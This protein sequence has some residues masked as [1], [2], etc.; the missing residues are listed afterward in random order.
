MLERLPSDVGGMVYDELSLLELAALAD[1]QPTQ[2]AKIEA[3][4]E[5]WLRGCFE[6]C[7]GSLAWLNVDWRFQMYN[8]AP[9]DASWERLKAGCAAAGWMGAWRALEA[10]RTEYLGSTPQ[11]FNGGLHLPETL[12][13]GDEK[14]ERLHDLPQEAPLRDAL[15]RCALYHPA[16]VDGLPDGQNDEYPVGVAFYRRAALSDLLAVNEDGSVDE[17]AV[18]RA[19]VQ[20]RGAFY[21]ACGEHYVN[22][23]ADYVLEPMSVSALLAD[24]PS[25]VWVRNARECVD[26]FGFRRVERA[27]FDAA[28]RCAPFVALCVGEA[29]ALTP[30]QALEVLC[31]T[32]HVIVKEKLEFAKDCEWKIGVS[33]TGKYEVR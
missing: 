14:W 18:E 12:P 26:E 21:P 6:L 19:I 17:K 1:A 27:I 22:N 23:A 29:P 24:L 11:K 3:L 16:I 9:L 31:G 13:W 33:Q 15:A 25:P 4:E 28:A 20:V 30:A 10:L 8:V 32:C 2:R 5:R 7:G